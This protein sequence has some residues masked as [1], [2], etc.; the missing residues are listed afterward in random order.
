MPLYII[1]AWVS[2]LSFGFSTILGKLTSRHQLKNQWQFG[3]FL[4][5]F[6][7]LFII[8]ISIFNGASFP[9]QWSNI[10]MAG[11]VNVAVNVFF[12]MALEHLDV[13][14]LAPLFNFRSV[15][16]V[17][18]GFLLLGEVLV[19]QDYLLIGVIFFAGLFATYDKAWTAKSFFN[20]GVF[21][22]LGMMLSL[23]FKGVFV[24]KAVATQGFW[25]ASLWINVVTVM[26]FG[27]FIPRFYKDL[28]ITPLKQYSGV[29]LM[30]VTNF[31][32][33]LTANAAYAGHVGV[34]S[35]IIS[36]PF[37]MFMAFLFS[38][39]KPDLLEKHSIKIYIVRFSAATIMIIAALKLSS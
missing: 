39:F 1:F 13:S 34:S 11:I 27:L 12:I 15:F 6:I 33:N 38:I 2:S 23:A 25:T 22:A 19:V 3:F 28:F 21:I 31:I 9:T 24:N 7:A 16:A 36:L 29:L 4:T 26:V 20:K 17:L 14:V 35:V 10:A 5:L 30:S 37:S 32:G 18:L 8:P